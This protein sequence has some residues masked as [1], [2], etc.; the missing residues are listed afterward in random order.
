MSFF[1]HL[2][3]TVPGVYFHE[4]AE[5]TWQLFL[6]DWIRFRANLVP[7]RRTFLGHRQVIDG[8]IIIRNW[9]AVATDICYS[10]SVP[11]LGLGSFGVTYLCGLGTP[12][13]GTRR[14]S[15]VWRGSSE[16]KNSMR[17]LPANWNKSEKSAEKSN[18]YARWGT[19]T[20]EGVGAAGRTNVQKSD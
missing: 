11:Y 15:N 16:L 14:S 17:S 4:Y 6:I 19:S 12:Y 7:A 9:K 20:R 5:G 18:K 1:L 8:A 3:I 13:C 2:S 10:A